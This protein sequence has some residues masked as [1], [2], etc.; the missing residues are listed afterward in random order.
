MTSPPA[1]GLCSVARTPSSVRV[2]AD[3][4]VPSV[5]APTL[6]A[7]APRFGVSFVMTS[8][9]LLTNSQARQPVE[10]APQHPAGAE[11]RAERRLCAYDRVQRDG[12]PRV[13]GFASAVLVERARKLVDKI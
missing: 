6:P 7:R 10:P 9:P 8:L 13:V 4:T 5:G 11:E 3:P 2:S 1:A 12:G